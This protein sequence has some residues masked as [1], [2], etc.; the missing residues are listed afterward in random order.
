MLWLLRLCATWGADFSVFLSRDAAAL[1]DIYDLVEGSGGSSGAYWRALAANVSSAVH[2]HMWDDARGAY[3]DVIVAPA[4]QTKTGAPTATVG[5]GNG[6][7]GGGDG[8]GDNG[9]DN[10]GGGGFTRSFSP[11]DAVSNFYPLWLPNLP[12]GRADA[13]A[14]RLTD[15]GSWGLAVPLPSVSFADPSFSTDMWRGPAWVNTNYMVA[16][17]L[18]A[19]ADA[20]DAA[21]AVTD[22]NTADDVGAGAG[23]K[24]PASSSSSSTAADRR[25]LAL[26]LVAAALDSMAANYDRFGVI[27]E[28]VGA[29]MRLGRFFLRT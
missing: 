29:S 1:G 17:A 16:L 18:L 14:A 12:A 22:A 26:D 21:A 24:S 23:A 3:A 4:G 10:G 7:D 13:L 9:G 2:A 5:D 11:V 27:F 28:C 25:G 6:G 8:G 15:P 20:T 19:S